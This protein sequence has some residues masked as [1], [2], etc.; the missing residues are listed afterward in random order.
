MAMTN[1]WK[2]IGMFLLTVIFVTSFALLMA[3]VI[4]EWMVGCGESYVDAKGVRHINECIVIPQKPVK[5]T[6][7]KE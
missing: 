5:P 1:I 7:H 6:Y 4:L 3:I 2:R